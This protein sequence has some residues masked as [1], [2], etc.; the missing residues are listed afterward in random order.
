MPVVRK[1]VKLFMVVCLGFGLSLSES[2]TG[3]ASAG[4]P[5][6]EKEWTQFYG[7]SSNY[8]EPRDV[9][10]TADGGM[11]ILA[12]KTGRTD[13]ITKL[14]VIKTDKNGTVEW[15]KEF[16]D[17][18]YDT[19]ALHGYTI[20]QVS[21]G[22]YIIGAAVKDNSDG[23]PIYV[24]YL[25]KLSS[26]GSK[27][28][29]RIY[30]SK[31]ANPVNSVRE[32]S[33][34][35]FIVTSSTYN[36]SDTAPAYILK[37]DRD[38][39]KEWEQT[40]SNSLEN[41]GAGQSFWDAVPAL[42]GGYWAIGDTQNVNLPRSYPLLVKYSS[43][44]KFVSRRIKE[45]LDWGR[46]SYKQIEAAP[47]GDGYTML[48]AEGLW[49]VGSDGQTLWNKRL[50]DSSPE[51]SGTSFD[52]LKPSDH[53]YEVIG[54]T[55]DRGDLVTVK[56]SLGGKIIS[57]LHQDIPASASTGGFRAYLPDGGLALLG[58]SENAE[59]LNLTSFKSALP[60]GE[61]GEIDGVFTL[62]SDEYS[63]TVNQSIDLIALFKKSDGSV[64]PVTGESKFSIEHPEIASIDEA[65]D[66]TGLS[67]GITQITAEYQGYK[68]TA[69]LLVVRPYLPK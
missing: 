20:T 57:V 12:D 39:K 15:D 48:N 10:P 33:D 41:F 62:D 53:G 28:W 8:N 30:V 64:I 42:D 46:L 9:A 58:T 21:D 38:G 52:Y 66:I 16:F 19:D 40:F 50:T 36:R 55:K 65:G 44:G 37:T 11:V 60:G 45:S 7:D 61:P 34:G 25:L 54:S 27:E 31:V 4:S 13:Y 3:N 26:S 63:L 47:E 24:A 23:R 59:Q 17:N 18:Q 68:A 56:V 43:S 14:N 2:G 6:L 51:L 22:G 67:P 35:G 5:V 1:Y 69:T 29:G 49:K 32:T